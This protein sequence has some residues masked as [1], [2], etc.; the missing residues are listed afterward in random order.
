[1]YSYTLKRVKSYL[2][3]SMNDGRLDSLTILNIE[4]WNLAYNIIKLYL[5]IITKI[6]E[7]FIRTK[8]NRQI[9]I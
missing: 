8:A 4:S 3:S 7:D 9:L 1:M 6:N 5:W 2:R